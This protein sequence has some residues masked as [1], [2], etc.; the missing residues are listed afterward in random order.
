LLGH[1]AEF[2]TAAVS[3]E[4]AEALILGAKALAITALTLIT[5]RDKLKEIKD[6]FEVQRGR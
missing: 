5:D 3:K 2:R 6:E 1:T 4:G